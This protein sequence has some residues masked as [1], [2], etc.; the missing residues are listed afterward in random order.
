MG[1]Q[2]N[3]FD[4][5]RVYQASFELQ[6]TIFELSAGFPKAERYALTDQVRR[7]S[8]SVGANIAEAWKKRRYE[9]HFIAKLSD[10]DAELAETEHW[11]RTARACGYLSPE[12]LSSLR[13]QSRTVG[14]MLG[15]M[16]R[17]PAP[18]CRRQNR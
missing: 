7:S 8:R 13:S 3:G 11:L 2:V 1:E 15:A 12:A 14:K 10:A 18:W 17:N 9:A 5:L 4:E 6:Q 16:L